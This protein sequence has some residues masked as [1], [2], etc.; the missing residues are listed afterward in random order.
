MQTDGSILVEW[1]SVASHR[2]QLQSA[3]AA[4]RAVWADVGSEVT[5][6]GDR[7]SQTDRTSDPARPRFYRFYASFPITSR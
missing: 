7:S 3:S 5:A 2:Y 1:A 4:G 6:N